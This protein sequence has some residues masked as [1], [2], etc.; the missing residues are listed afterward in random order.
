MALKLK[1]SEYQDIKVLRRIS[2]LRSYD[3]LEV[4]RRKVIL[5]CVRHGEW[6]DTQVRVL[7]NSAECP[8]CG[9]SRPRGRMSFTPDEW[10]E[11]LRAI[12]PHIRLIDKALVLEG[13][14]LFRHKCRKC[15]AKFKNSIQALMHPQFKCPECDYEL[16]ESRRIK[17]NKFRA[18]F[19]ISHGKAVKNRDSLYHLADM[20]AAYATLKEIGAVKFPPAIELSEQTRPTPEQPEQQKPEPEEEVLDL[21]DLITQELQVNI[22]DEQPLELLDSEST[23]LELSDS[24]DFQPESFDYGRDAVAV[25]AG[26]NGSAPVDAHGRNIKKDLKWY[27]GI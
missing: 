5:T 9:K 7:A 1:A 20:K 10:R 12:Q 19:K 8:A 23:E 22:E 11:V 6:E 17:A 3:V 24:T 16:P 13:R 4:N 27:Y 18:N 21:D 15:G 25:Y 26:R 14:T 2:R